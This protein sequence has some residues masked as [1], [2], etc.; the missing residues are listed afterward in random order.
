MVKVMNVVKS[1]V[2]EIVAV[3]GGDGATES[4][5]EELL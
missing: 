3:V 2:V 4:G 5:Q 1:A